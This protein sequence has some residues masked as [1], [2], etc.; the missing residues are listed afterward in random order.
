MGLSRLVLRHGAF[1]TGR[2][3]ARASGF[4]IDMNVV[5]QEFLTQALREVLGPRHSR[6]GRI[7][8]SRV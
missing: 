5:F 7:A 2:G 1:E 4:L 3:A 6:C 8:S